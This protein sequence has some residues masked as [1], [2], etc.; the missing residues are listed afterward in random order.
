LLLL[1]KNNAGL[2]QEQALEFQVVGA[3]MS[4]L[5]SHLLR[6][7][8]FGAASEDFL[9][10]HRHS[11]RNAA[12]LI[13]KFREDGARDS[14]RRGGVRNGQAE[15]LNALAWNQASRVRRIFHR[16]DATS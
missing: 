1:S 4:E 8:A 14:G 5:I 3:D 12:F 6:Q 2:G 16:Q 7:P 13:Y 10:T 11:R 15:W 9:Q